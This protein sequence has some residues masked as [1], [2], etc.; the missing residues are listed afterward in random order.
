ML[1]AASAIYRLKLPK[2]IKDKIMEQKVYSEDII[3]ISFKME[4]NYKKIPMKK[5]KFLP[6]LEVNIK[7]FKQQIA[8]EATLETTIDK[9]KSRIARLPL[10]EGLKTINVRI[11]GNKIIV[12]FKV[13][14]GYAQV[15]SQ[16][17]DFTPASPHDAEQ[18]LK[19]ISEVRNLVLTD[20]ETQFT[21][22][23]GK[24]KVIDTLKEKLKLPST[25]IDRI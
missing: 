10:P 4:Q 22:Y 3:S 17:I 23:E 2:G 9:A 15:D 13:K 6:I 18:V 11:E 12:D 14:E 16:T 19:Y 21:S 1:E 20:G 5:F 25:F 7:E 8:R 24:K